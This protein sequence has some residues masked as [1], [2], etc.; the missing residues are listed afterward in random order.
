MDSSEWLD[1][2]SRGL[3]DWVIEYNGGKPFRCIKEG[4]DEQDHD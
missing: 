3:P 1:E 4:E 2:I